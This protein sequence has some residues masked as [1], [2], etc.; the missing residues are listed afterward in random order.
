MPDVDDPIGE[1]P[2]EDTEPVSPPPTVPP[3]EGEPAGEGPEST[4]STPPG[5]P[6]RDPF[7]GQGES[8]SLSTP[9][10]SAPTHARGIPTGSKGMILQGGRAAGETRQYLTE[11]QKQSNVLMAKKTAQTVGAATPEGRR[12]VDDAFIW[13]EITGETLTFQMMPEIITESKAANWTPTSILGRTE[14]IQGFESSGE[15]TLQLEL[16]FLESRD[17]NDTSSWEQGV[18]VFEKVKW[19]RSLVYADYQQQLIRPPH[20]VYIFIGYLIWMRAICRD[21]NVS[22][23]SPWD[24]KSLYPIF[25][26]VNLTFAECNEM[27][28][29]DFFDVRH[30][31]M[32]PW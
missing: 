20:A 18:Y 24:V 31:H 27:Y 26:T 5:T 2:G 8:R 28:I 16:N 3:A 15:R 12:E 25:A 10:L 11:T 7:A 19:L 6:T 22:Y 17:Q 13:D 1:D 23:K 14:P 9:D 21:Y 30:T 29:P 4:P 32:P